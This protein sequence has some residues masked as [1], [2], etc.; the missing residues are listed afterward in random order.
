MSKEQ[1]NGH[2]PSGEEGDAI[3][4]NF[5]EP[6]LVS[7]TRRQHFSLDGHSTA[8]LRPVSFENQLVSKLMPA[9]SVWADRASPQV[10]V[11]MLCGQNL[12]HF[13]DVHPR[14]VESTFHWLVMH[15]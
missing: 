9:H 11:V 2:A 15:I 3:S 13:L 5:P 14:S 1:R 10:E 12:S 6:T 8:S 7:S 4:G